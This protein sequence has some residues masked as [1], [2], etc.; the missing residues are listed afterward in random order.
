MDTNKQLRSRPQ[1]TGR[2][3]RNCG[4]GGRASVTLSNSATAG[5]AGKTYP[6]NFD[7][8]A[9]KK[10]RQKPAQRSAKSDRAEI[11]RSA[12]GFRPPAKAQSRAALHGRNATRT[13]GA[14]YQN[15]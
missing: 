2:E 7:R 15:G 13:T 10:R 12:K 4:H 11:L 14:E 6:G 8:E 1:R 5:N 3:R 9:E